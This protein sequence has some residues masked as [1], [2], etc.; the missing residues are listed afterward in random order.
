M[1]QCLLA[2]CEGDPPAIGMG[3]YAWD[4]TGE[5]MTMYMDRKAGNVQHSNTCQVLVSR[6]T[7]LV[8]SLTLGVR[9]VEILFPPIHIPTTSTEWLRNG[10]YW[11]KLT[12][13]VHVLVAAIL[14]TALT[15]RMQIDEADFASSND[16]HI[17]YLFDQGYPGKSIFKFHDWCQRHSH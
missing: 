6:M 13:R 15:I 17:H 7:V 1:I 12:R 5:R 2:A 9:Y 4:E 10:L 3:R 11:H 16:K 14:A 8:A